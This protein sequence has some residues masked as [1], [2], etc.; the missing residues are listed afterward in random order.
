VEI[1]KVDVVG[2]EESQA[3]LDRTSDHFGTA[4]DPTLVALDKNT[5]LRCEEELLTPSMERVADQGFVLAF[6][7]YA[8][9]V[10]MVVTDIECVVE[11]LCP[12][13]GGGRYS[14]SPAERHT[15]KTDRVNGMSSNCSSF[16]CGQ[17]GNPT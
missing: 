14:I 10:E 16:G 11:Q 15:A 12:V 2:L 7:I 4:I 3:L 6:A 9:R 13:L 1:V 8:R 5:G 17:I